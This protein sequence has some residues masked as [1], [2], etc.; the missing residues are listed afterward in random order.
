MSG[1]ESAGHSYED[2][3]DVKHFCSVQS[4]LDGRMSRED[5]RGEEEDDEGSR[6]NGLRKNRWANEKKF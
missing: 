4:R 1:F 6:V 5:R 3:E 2:E